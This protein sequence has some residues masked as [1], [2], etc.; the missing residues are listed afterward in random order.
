MGFPVLVRWNLISSQYHSCWFPGPFHRQV[1]RNHSINHAWL[2]GPGFPQWRFSTSCAISVMRYDIKCRHIPQINS[3][4][5]VLIV[6]AYITARKKPAKPI[7]SFTMMCMPGLFCIVIHVKPRLH[8]RGFRAG[9]TRL[10]DPCTTSSTTLPWP[11]A[12]TTVSERLAVFHRLWIFELRQKS[13][14]VLF[15]RHT[16]VPVRL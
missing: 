2:T 16:N 10:D 9:C 12:W 14:P 1:I 7:K 11:R 15:V 6:L 8:S 3:A 4:H 5:S 13:E